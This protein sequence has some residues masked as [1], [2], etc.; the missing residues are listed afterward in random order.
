[1]GNMVQVDTFHLTHGNVKHSQAGAGNLAV[2]SCVFLSRVTAEVQS[3][4][5]IKVAEPLSRS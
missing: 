3:F 5:P 4:A 2:M 1:M